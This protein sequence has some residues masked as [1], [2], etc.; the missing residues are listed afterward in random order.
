[1][2]G[3]KAQSA[4]IRINVHIDDDLAEK[5]AIPQDLWYR[6]LNRPQLLSIVIWGGSPQVPNDGFLDNS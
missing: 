3:E 4:S 5:E 2:L 6:N 1:M